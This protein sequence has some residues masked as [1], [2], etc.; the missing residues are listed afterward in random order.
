M[1]SAESLE[2]RMSF[3]R[4]WLSSSSPPSL[5]GSAPSHL[6]SSSRPESPIHIDD[7]FDDRDDDRDDDRGDDS[8][9]R[10]RKIPPSKS[11]SKSLILMELSDMDVIERAIERVLECTE[12]ITPG[13]PENY[14]QVVETC[15]DCYVRLVRSGGKLSGGQRSGGKRSG[16]DPYQR[17]DLLLRVLN[18]R[19]PA[20]PTG[21]TVK[22]RRTYNRTSITNLEK[23]ITLSDMGP[24]SRGGG[25]SLGVCGDGD[26]GGGGGE[27]VWKVLKG[28]L[29]EGE[30]GGDRGGQR[31]GERAGQPAGEHAQAMETIRHDDSDEFVRKTRECPAAAR[32]ERGANCQFNSPPMHEVIIG[33]FVRGRVGK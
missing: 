19:R 32:G 20:L 8:V 15:V 21:G 17:Q 6:P 26:V 2:S 33:N 18:I 16:E 4:N 14:D 10:K 28:W 13:S 22:R 9:G 3:L 29:V 1:D 27:M 11:P 5:S 12:S 7:S 25:A 24:F 31:E 30:G 23:L